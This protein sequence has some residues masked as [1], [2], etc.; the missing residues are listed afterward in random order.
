MAIVSSEAGERKILKTM[1]QNPH[2]QE[3]DM[4][5]I[6]WFLKPFR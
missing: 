1:G 2:C 3:K 4:K 5:T 6:F